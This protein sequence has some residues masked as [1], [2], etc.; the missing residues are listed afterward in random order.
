MLSKLATQL[1]EKT[2]E[3]E[4]RGIPP[5]TFTIVFFGISSGSSFEGSKNK[6]IWVTNG[7][8]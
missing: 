1:N 7:F 6:P 8:L 5:A 3:L 4:V 2:F